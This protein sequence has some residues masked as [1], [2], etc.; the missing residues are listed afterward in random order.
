MVTY[1]YTDTQGTTIAEADAS[2]NITIAFDYRPYGSAYTGAGMSA[3][4]DGPGYTSHVN[5]PDTAL[6]YMQARY[7]DPSIGRFLSVDPINVYPGA[8]FPFNR[9]SYANDNPSVNIDPDGR[10]TGSHI[11]G[12]DGTC[13]SSGEF[14]TRAMN[15]HSYSPN[16]N[17]L[18]FNVFS[19]V[20]KGS[21]NSLSTSGYWN[22]KKPS[23]KGGIIVQDMAIAYQRTGDDESMA[24][25][26]DHYWEAWT[27]KPGETRTDGGRQIDDV[28]SIGPQTGHGGVSWKASAR[29][30]E[31][32]KLP[33]T[34]R[35]GSVQ[36]AQGLPATR[37]DPRLPLGNTSNTVDR[38]LNY[39]WP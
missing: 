33:P 7:Y 12:S 9:F 23:K 30:Y 26:N 14:T 22:L 16:V 34:F 17:A 37:E 36:H 8:L 18:S 10:C 21:D 39:T 2:G 35:E 5:D 38:E 19:P 20:S 31:G 4:S 29:F 27:V 24:S 3:A 15:A 28:F 32:R 25:E 1:I 11:S 13:V 6:I